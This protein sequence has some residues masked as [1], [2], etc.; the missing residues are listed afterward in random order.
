MPTRSS[1]TAATMRCCRD[2]WTRTSTSINPDAPNGRASD[3]ATRAAAAGGYTTLVD[4]PL[5]CLPETTTVAALEEKRAAAQGECF[6]DWAR[7]GRSRRRQSA[8]HS[9]A[10][11]RR[12]PRL[13]MLPHLPRLRRLHHDRPATARGRT[14][15]HRRIR[16]APPRAR[17]TGGTDRRR[18]ERPAQRR[19]AKLR[20]LPCLTP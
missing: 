5:N 20:N 7:V 15:I 3:T 13:Q 10:R 1:S 2:W 19:L 16:P 11:A 6:V 14:T 4:M 9:A 17:R 8:A 18:D 12:R